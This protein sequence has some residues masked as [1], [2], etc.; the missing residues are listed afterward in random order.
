VTDFAAVDRLLDELAPV[1]H[2]EPEAWADVLARAELL[3]AGWNG[4]VDGRQLARLRPR[5]RPRR[6]A[7]RRLLVLA[8]AAL[9][10]VLVAAAAYALSRTVV[11]FGSAPRA[12]EKVVVDFGRT[13]IGAPPGMATNV[14]PHETR[15]IT[16]V[17]I[18]GQEHVLWVAPTAQG[19]F[20]ELWWEL[21]GGCR[22]KRE[23]GLDVSVGSTGTG[24]GVAVLEGSFFDGAGERLEVSFADGTSDEIPFVWVTAPID[25]GFFIYRVPDA[26]RVHERRP[27]SLTLL[28]GSG[29][30]LL[31]TSVIDVAAHAPPPP[32]GVERRLPGLGP[33]SV[34]PWAEWSKR[35]RL[36][37]W[38]VEG[39]RYLALWVAPERSGATCMWAGGKNTLLEGCTPAGGRV[40]PIASL[41]LYG[42]TTVMLCCEVGRAVARIEADFQGG[43][44][45]ELAPKDGYL[46]WPIPSRHEAPGSRLA[47][48]VAYD[49]AGR[50]LARRRMPTGAA[51]YACATRKPPKGGSTCP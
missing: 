21:V 35:R 26:N 13:D 41:G 12:P 4:R 44:R 47:R 43:D 10:L 33:V 18:D 45:V 51:F 42:A 49:I 37:D 19:G 27:V 8:A 31:E 11:D 16:S 34:G 38:R 46:L 9:V 50:V 20:C 24:M 17:T 14:L 40:A 15:R 29:N 25:A 23:G 39:G 32:N 3:A 1:V 22:A 36:F 5:L 48:L 30:V 28:D 7:R 6:A 2:E